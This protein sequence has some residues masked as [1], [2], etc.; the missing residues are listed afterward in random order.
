ME[1]NDKIYEISRTMIIENKTIKFRF[2][3]ST[4]P[5]TFSATLCSPT[6]TL[7]WTRR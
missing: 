4:Q 1:I 5:E 3:W 7:D 6:P 2:R